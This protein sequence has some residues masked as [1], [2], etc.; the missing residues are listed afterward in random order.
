MWAACGVF[1]PLFYGKVLE[2]LSCVL[3]AVVS[4][5]T[6]LGMPNSEKMPLSLGF[7]SSER[8]DDSFL[9]TKYEE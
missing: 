1:K 7:T 3:W 6:L 5:I 9:T 4:L 2:V 8:V